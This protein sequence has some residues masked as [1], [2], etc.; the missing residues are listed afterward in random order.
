MLNDIFIA[1]LKYYTDNER[2]INELWAEIEQHYTNKK[3]HY[4]TLEHL[5]K[6][7]NQLSEIKNEIQHWH[8]LLF[9]LFYHDIIYNTLKSDNE[10]K[11][12]ALAVKRLTQLGIADSEIRLCRHQILATKSHEFSENTDTNYF[13]DADLS[14]LGQ[15]WETYSNYILQVREEYAIYPD[16]IYKKGRKKVV[17][18]FLA[19]KYIYKTTF[20]RNTLEQQ[21]KQNLQKEL[22]I[23]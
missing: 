15:N 19:M 23:L 10:E 9:S 7:F 2:L 21:A 6:L 8:I 17:H 3:R 14:I 20:F 4:H 22:S 13:T 12:A 1:L 5:N 11:S 18:H 16:F